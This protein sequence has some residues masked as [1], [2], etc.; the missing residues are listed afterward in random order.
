ML[1]AGV[2]AGA[3]TVP[4][5]PA[6]A[7]GSGVIIVPR[8][9]GGRPDIAV[10]A[11]CESDYRRSG[12]SRTILY[13]PGYD[14]A[15]AS[16]SVLTTPFY[17]YVCVQGLSRT[18]NGSTTHPYM[19]LVFDPNHDGGAAPDADDLNLALG[20][21]N[22]MTEYHGNGTGFVPQAS[23]SEWFA[24]TSLSQEIG[25][26]AEFRINLSKIG[27]P[28]PGEVVGF[29]ARHT[30]LQST[31][32][33]FPWPADS[34]N[35]RP[36]T[37]GDLFFLGPNT[38][39][40]GAV[41]LDAGRV[42]Q[43]LEWDVAQGANKPYEF[44][45]GKDAMV[46]GR[47]YTLGSIT[48]VT[49]RGCRVQRISPVTDPPRTLA[50]DSSLAPRVFPAPS[51]VLGTMGDFRCWVPGADLRP[52]GVYRFSLVVRMAGGDEQVVDVATRDALRTRAVRM[53]IYRWIFP[54]GHAE[55]R[56]WDAALNASAMDSMRDLQRVLPVPAGVGAYA[57]DSPPGPGAPGL[58]YF[59]SPTVY[60]CVR[61]SGETMNQA[62]GRCD[63]TIRNNADLERMEYDR[64]ARS[65]DDNDGGHRDRIDLQ[66]TYVSTPRSGGGQ[67]CWANSAS[68][69]SG[70]DSIPT[71][72]SHYVPIQE[73]EHCWFQLRDDSPHS[74]PDDH[75]HSLNA[76]FWPA[77]GRAMVNL[78]TREE[79]PEPRS[80]MFPTFDNGDFSPTRHETL[81][82]EGF[83]FNDL[84]STLLTLPSPSGNRAARA[85][86]AGTAAGAEYQLAFL[87]DHTTEPD[88]FTLQTARRL[89]GSTLTPTTPDQS[90]PFSLVF[91]DDTDKVTGVLPFAVTEHG[92]HP[93][94]VPIDVEG[95]VLVA[96]VPAD[97]TKVAIEEDGEAQP[98]FTDEFTAAAPV[99]SDVQ[100][101][102]NGPNGVDVTWTGTD[103]DS[104]ALSYSVYFQQHPGSV[105]T[106]VANGI[107][108]PGYEF[109]TTFAPGTDD[110]VITVEAT[111]GWNTGE[112]SV[113][114]VVVADK[115]PFV[116]ISSP[117]PGEMF[118]ESQKVRLVG[119]GYDQNS[120]GELPGKALTWKVDGITVGAGQEIT[121]GGLLP[122][123]HTATL[124]AETPAGTTRT[125]PV[126]FRVAAD[127]DHDGIGDAVEAKAP[128]LDPKR[129]DSTGDPD[130]DGLPTSQEVLR[131]TNPCKADTDVDGASDGDEVAGGSDPRSKKD[132][133]D[134]PLIFV[135]PVQLDLGTCASPKTGH[136]EVQTRKPDVQWT[137]RPDGFLVL[138][139]SDKRTTGPG[140]ITVKPD[141]AGLNK[142]QTYLARVGVQAVDGRQ[143]HIVDV[144]FRT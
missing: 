89:D 56:M 123:P 79:I 63:A 100:A 107:P 65:R 30:A 70:L 17:L 116:S 58:R 85:G 126:K 125:V 120:M 31:N 117:A 76:F 133:P 59:F 23:T 36:Q 124:T 27:D 118:L 43:G 131:G 86:P 28:H 52:P 106:L 94:D 90:S 115:K 61:D 39:T 16:F 33:S 83:E 4:S 35:R 9:L 32:D 1:V 137:D 88:G 29:Q 49:F 112:A 12:N 119:S 46:Q 92:T 101:A 127:S 62:T 82:N 42:T 75:P 54:A 57:F 73:A 50:V 48:D 111:D 139:S 95:Q 13:R 136:I 141:C 41:R 15:P 68:A 84:R 105:R 53:M 34:E 55:N 69:G 37:W 77:S 7:H 134:P 143:I 132:T 129:F 20:E 109:D 45:A 47:L 8:Q 10:D 108:K 103:A 26:T 22:R 2:V 25:W 98:L 87:M 64:Q 78:Q 40:P 138:D 93:H 128:C 144:R 71:G 142:G 51:G 102:P 67:S 91:R 38:T 19:S 72:Q 99:V 66:Q 6:S 135:D 140:V 97:S 121:V 24:R 122:G 14:Y 104:G 80:V 81:I 44:V 114:D 11:N 130:K 96:D 18:P 5:A 74:I 110:G 60:Q 21:N 3:L 113:G